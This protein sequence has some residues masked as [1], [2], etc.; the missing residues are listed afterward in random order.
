AM[1]AMAVRDDGARHRPT[2]VDME[3]AGRA[4]DPAGIGPQQILGAQ[5]HAL[6]LPWRGAG[7]HRGRRAGTRLLRPAG[8]RTRIAGT[9]CENPAVSVA[10]GRYRGRTWLPGLGECEAGSEPDPPPAVHG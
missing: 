7:D 3:A 6:P 2:R 1:I 9:S 10:P 5:G 8:I 4:E